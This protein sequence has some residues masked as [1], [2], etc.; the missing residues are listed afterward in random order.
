[1]K[2]SFKQSAKLGLGRG[3]RQFLLEIGIGA[4]RKARSIA[5]A[6]RSDAGS[7]TIEAFESVCTAKAPLTAFG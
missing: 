1:M 7:A 3:P 4:A 6:L 2:R 5:G